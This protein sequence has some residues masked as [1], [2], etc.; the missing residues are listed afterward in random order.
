MCYSMNQGSGNL[1]SAPQ[2][3]DADLTYI[4]QWKHL[5]AAQC[6]E[7]HKSYVQI[8]PVLSLDK[9]VGRQTAIIEGMTTESMRNVVTVFYFQLVTQCGSSVDPE[10]GYS[11]LVLFLY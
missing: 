2:R 5:G 6:A 3:S 1:R 11:H 8:P 4:P 9:H 7:S 10:E